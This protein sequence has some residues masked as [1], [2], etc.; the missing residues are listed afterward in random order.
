[1]T[2]SRKPVLLPDRLA[3]SIA[4]SLLALAAVSWVASYYLMPLMASGSSVM[5]MGVAG[6]VSSLSFSS[7]GFFEIVWVIGMAAMMFPAMIPIVLF[8]NKIATKQEANPLLARV[9]GTPLFLSGYLIMYAILGLGA[10]LVVYESINL[11][12]NFSALAALSVLAS[13]AILIVTGIYQFTPLK[14]RCLSN[15][16][17]PMGF[18]A[19]HLRKGLVGTVQMGLKN[20]LYCVGCCWAF[21]LVMLAIGAMSIPVMAALAGLI[22]VEKVIVRGAMWFNRLVA[23]GFIALG[24][25]V[26]VFPNILAFI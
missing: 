21:M 5:S 10:Y 2:E 14:S 12:M 1:M 17:S 6:I 22:A 7:V 9:V 15:C 16:V 13:S 18:F 26:L 23:V 24:V 25:A 4:F 11:S 8:Y 20:G 3:I 19:V